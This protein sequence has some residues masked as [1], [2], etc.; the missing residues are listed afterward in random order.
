MGA[1][2]LQHTGRS[3]KSRGTGPRGL[4]ALRPGAAIVLGLF[5]C[6]GALLLSA[7]GASATPSSSVTLYVNG[8]SGTVTTGCTSAG[9]GACETI[10]QGVAAAEALSDT[11][12]TLDVAAGTYAA[13]V[14]VDV[15]STDTLTVLG[16]GSSTTTVDDAGTGNDFS[17][18]AGTVTIDGFTISGGTGGASF[19]GAGVSDTD[20]DLVTLDNDTV[21]SNS[22]SEGG[23]GVYT[24]D[25]SLIAE[26][27]TF[28]DNSGGAGAAFYIDGGSVALDQDTFSGGTASS[29]GGAI[30]MNGGSTATL[31]QDTFS[32]DSATYGGA[33]YD[34][35]SYA[36]LINDTFAGD[37]ATDSG[38]AMLNFGGTV[39][40]TDDTIAGDSAAT[41]D[42]GG[43][44]NVEGTTTLVDTLLADDTGGS[45]AG[46]TSP[47]VTDGEY[48]V[49]SDAS[50]D[51]GADSVSSSTDIGTLTL[52]ANGS[53]GPETEAISTGSSAF[54]EVP[55]SA[56]TVNVDERDEPRPATA[57]PN[58]DAGA[59][60]LQFSPTTLYVN[61]TSGTVTTGCTSPGT[62]ACKTISE[63][64]T[65][66][67]LLSDAAVTVDVAAGT[68]DEQ[69]SITLPSDDVLT[70]DGAGASSTT[71][72]DE[73]SGSDIDLVGG[74]L[75]IEGLTVGGGNT[76][77][78]GGGLYDGDSDTLLV[79]DHDT[80][81]DDTSVEGGGAV[82]TEGGYD[83]FNDDL[84]SGNSATDGSGAVELYYT[85]G[86]MVGD[87]FSGNSDT[88]F[89]KFAGALGE[90][91]GTLSVD[92]STFTDNSSTGGHS[93]GGAASPTDGT[94]T[95][96]NDTFSGNSATYGGALFTGSTP[97]DVIF[98]NDTVA[99]NTSGGA[100]DG[101]G[102]YNVGGGTGLTLAN[103][104]LADNSGGDCVG[105]ITDGNYNVADD[106]SCGFGSKSISS[107]ATIGALNLA[108]NGSTGPETEAITGTSSAFDE[109]PASACTLSTDERGLPRPG[110]NVTG[111]DAGAYEL[112]TSTQSISFTGPGTGAVGST[113][114]LHATGGGSG[115]PIT[116][117][118]DSSSG[119][120][121]CSVS[122]STVT[123]LAK[124][125][126]VLDANQAGNAVYDAAPQVT[127]S[128]TVGPVLSGYDLVGTDGGVFVFPTGQSGGFYGSLP[129]IGVH[130]N[131]IVG[132]VPTANDQGYFLVGADGGVFAFGNAPFE[133]S[134]PGIGIHVNDIVGIV[135]TSSDK[136][137]F[138]V[139]SDGGVFTFGNASFLGS[140][141]GIGIHVTN[142]IGIAANPS[143]TGYWLV[144]STGTVYSFGTAKNFG[145]ATGSSAPV[146]AIESTPDGGGYWIVTQVG[147]V[148][149]F[150]DAKYFGSL[151]GIKVTPTHPVI[152]IVPTSDD[153]GYWLIGSDGGIFAF[154]DAP[155]V[156]SLPGLGVSV[157]NIVGAVP[158]HP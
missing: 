155:F 77:A 107:S 137:Y 22:A 67:E 87:T 85:D 33:L 35:E 1:I 147:A 138:L 149:S 62:G 53:T 99:G 125:T 129:G 101:G 92:D 54:A 63:G 18:D 88:G 97:N 45:C 145:S 80:F 84:F 112:Q 30:Y 144:A 74:T 148:D 79:L 135:P 111:C 41:D 13:K 93:Y 55:P 104:L 7:P 76:S 98:E 17:V 82:F 78:Y 36:Y 83:L 128:V 91:Y 141:P 25:G 27:D 71:L 133:N 124:G 100:G 40:V 142:I 5:L 89:E 10:P 61:G 131:D 157:T 34:Y 103:T 73:G 106:A 42:G 118:V 158:T 132:M 56:C 150:G 28:S 143:D 136:G 11:A 57:V 152:G 90:S 134:L 46:T 114:T 86:V 43:I 48:N 110:A 95:F 12:V 26:N 72:D 31:A 52:A 59:F 60:E 16:A 121:V 38:G 153:A 123:Y 94:A 6:S 20:S 102:V 44:M 105:V 51:F 64:V 37:S 69:V 81:T 115:N 66:A 113:A 139:G 119:T 47:P 116:F 117:R 130:V 14:V 8:T 50:C 32:D 70:L 75:A 154:G 49:A 4:P 126:C 120:G 108:A 15:P 146:S 96:D 109:V 151:P 39:S 29:D 19:Y 156:G 9:A 122:G 58:C 3:W 23:G 24:D 140:L 68:Y 65:A 127:Q 2:R 21:S